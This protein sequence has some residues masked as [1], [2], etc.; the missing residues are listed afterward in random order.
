MRRRL[1]AILGVLSWIGLSGAFGGSFTISVSVAGAPGVVEGTSRA[2]LLTDTARDGFLGF[3]DGDRRDADMRLFPLEFGRAV[4]DDYVLAVMEAI[5]V[6]GVALIESGVFEVAL[7]ETIWGGLLQ[8]GDPLGLLL[9]YDGHLQE[10]ARVGLYRTDTITDPQYGGN[11][12]YTLPSEGASVRI[13]SVAEGLELVAGVQGQVEVSDFANLD[14]TMG[15]PVFGISTESIRFSA[16]DTSNPLELELA[17]QMPGLYVVES[18]LDMQQWHL[19]EERVISE[20]ASWTVTDTSVMSAERAFYR[21]W[22][23]P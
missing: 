4:G 1:S 21:W 3:G 15:A 18:S 10:G 13:V 23:Y 22:R 19:L 9:L 16:P 8:A 2:L 5:T 7:A 17:T 6:D 14:R 12:A 11:H 20:G